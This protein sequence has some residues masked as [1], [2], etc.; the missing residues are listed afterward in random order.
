M[1]ANEAAP[2]TR[3]ILDGRIIPH[4]F[5]TVNVLESPRTNALA[6]GPHTEELVDTKAYRSNTFSV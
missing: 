1:R 3:A 2:P 5:V 4:Y 6:V